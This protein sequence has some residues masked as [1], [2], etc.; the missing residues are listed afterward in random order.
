VLLLLGRFE[1]G[2]RHYEWRWRCRNFARYRRQFSIP[3]W[4][5]LAAPDQT[6]L[7]HAEQGLGDTLLFFRYLPLVRER[8][9]GARI[10]FAAPSELR[11]I[12]TANAPS[13]VEIV[14]L[15]KM[16]ETGDA[17]KFDQHIPLLSVPLAVQQ[18]APLPMTQPSLSA[19]TALRS[20]WR[21]RLAASRGLRVGLVW[22]GN[23][24]LDRDRHRSIE[25][26]RLAPLLR[27][28]G[29]SF[30]SLQLES[31]GAL[32]PVMTESS[33][34]DLTP[35][36]TDFADTAAAV[37]ELDLV[38]SVDT[39]T[40]HLAGALGRP[41]WTLLPHV[42]DWRWGLDREDTPWYPTMRLFRQKSAGDWDEVIRRIGNA[43]RA[44]DRKTL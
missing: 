12:L 2:W 30:H 40:A 37:A 20:A 39:A 31:R 41:V 5:G 13:G 7:V 4:T 38:I 19:D 36:I 14:C 8:A 21:E 9:S 17:P 6:I 29:V 24:Q 27:T 33:V 16:A 15:E 35:S 18:F 25:P 34:L 10:S 22:A 26:D 3:Q 11:R 23:R 1:E 43:L 32:P 28:P 44:A 42:P